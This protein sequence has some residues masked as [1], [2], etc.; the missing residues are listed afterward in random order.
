MNIYANIRR[1]NMKKRLLIL[2][3]IAGFV[4]SGCS[5]EDLKFW[6]KINLDSVMFWKN[7]EEQKD[8]QQSDSKDD[9]KQ[10][11]DEGEKEDE[12][13]KE[14]ASVVSV[15]VS[16]APAYAYVVEESIQLTAEVSVTGGAATSVSWSSSDESVATV[17]SDGVVTLVAP[18]NV[19]IT[20]TSTFDSSKSGSAKFEVKDAGPYSEL[21]AYGYDYSVDWPEEELNGFA[22]MEVFSIEDANGFYYAASPASENSPASFTIVGVYT[23][24]LGSSVSTEL[25]N[26]D[27]FWFED[28]SY[29]I[30]C[31]I[32]P[33]QTI[34]MEVYVSA[35]DEEGTKLCLVLEVYRTAEKFESS[36]P[37]TDTA[38][39]KET[40][41]ELANLGVDLPFVA[42]GEKYDVYVY[43]DGM[44]EIS[45]YCADFTK[46][47]GYDAVLKAAGYE[48]NE[49][50]EFVKSLDAYS[51]AVVYFLFN[52]YGNTI[53]VERRLK[54]LDNFPAD[55]VAAFVGEEGIN[56]KYSLPSLLGEGLK[57]TFDS[58]QIAM[59]E[60]ETDIRNAIEVG[61]LNVS[62]EQCFGYVES[63]VGEGYILDG[64]YPEYYGSTYAFLHKGK[65]CVQAV[66]NYSS[67][68]ATDEE[69]AAFEA[70][71]EEDIAAM[72]DDEYNDWMTKALEL[73]FTGTFTVYDYSK[74]TSAS[75]LVYGDPEGIEDPGVY[76]LVDEVNVALGGSYSIQ[77]FYWEVE[78]EEHPV[79]FVS[80]NPEVAT[81]NE[82]GVVTAVAL[83]DA[84]ITMTAADSEYS[85]T[86]VVHVINPASINDVIDDA[87]AWLAEQG[88]T[89][90]LEFPEIDD[91]DAIESFYDDEYGCY[92]IVATIS[93]DQE[94]AVYAYAEKMEEA[95]F[96]VYDETEDGYGFIVVTEE[97]EM[98]IWYWSD[99]TF[100]IDIYYSPALAGDTVDFS[101]YT[102]TSGETDSF[103]FVT[104]V[105]T[106]SNKQGAQYNEDSKELRLYIGN[107]LTI[108]SSEEMTE[109]FFDANTCTHAKA[110]GT[111]SASVGTI[112]EV[113]GG[114]YW[115]GS[116]TE[117]TFTVDSGKQVHI[118]SF[119]VAFADAE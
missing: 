100:N 98:Q 69:I 50:G 80:S 14:T 55:E 86:L 7:K 67:R 33:S 56:S 39:E 60:E 103:A 46:L 85:D 45:D 27:Y 66:I 99:G 43:S 21:I 4:L 5:A 12:G 38:W 77:P 13:Q 84:T 90:V 94:E 53:Q 75:I 78:A 42:L 29:E 47:D 52:Q 24:G 116:A 118:N 70:I 113:D 35:L 3:L 25:Y 73:A 32:D 40:A 72:T 109:I 111:L 54:E 8:E 92:S 15:S 74:V 68:S 110:D 114:F 95:G 10:K 105:G 20:A 57:Y 49:Y 89:E 104:D 76:I 2:P 79:S 37:T 101:E 93:G 1:E 9:E 88:A 18:G 119:T 59:D 41:E 23:D 71:T 112:E 64:S 62:E 31:F 28:T 19:V 11:E 91:L 26:G 107:T 87:N 30:D 51:Y 44:V 36:T 22:G 83:G 17:S 117:V 81:V 102:E 65:I 96:T 16:G 97:T 58:Y 115:T 61:V 6:E 63:L 106:N 82:N 48:E 34:E 108:S